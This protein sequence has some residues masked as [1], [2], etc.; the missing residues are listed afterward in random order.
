MAKKIESNGIPVALITAMSGL[1]KNIGVS[2]IIQA[3]AINNPTGDPEKSDRKELEER[4][5]ILQK[6][7]KALTTKVERGENLLL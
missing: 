3:V 1:A 2:R 4:I 6:A 5:E 7:F